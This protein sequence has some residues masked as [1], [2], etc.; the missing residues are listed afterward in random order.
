MIHYGMEC[1]EISLSSGLKIYRVKE[2]KT[3]NRLPKPKNN[4]KLKDYALRGP[5]VCYT[6]EALKQRMAE[7]D[8]KW[9]Y[10]RKLYHENPE[11]Y[12][13]LFK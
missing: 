4:L 5:S 12:Y 1:N 9:A 8:A 6:P 13:R 3:R 10:I 2:K 7:E 11:A